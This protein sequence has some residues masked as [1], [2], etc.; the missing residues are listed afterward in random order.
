[1][2]IGS[3]RWSVDEGDVREVERGGKIKRCA[4][5]VE[6][7]QVRRCALACWKFGTPVSHCVLR[8]ISRSFLFFLSANLVRG[9]E[10]EEE[11]RRKKRWVRARPFSARSANLGRYLAAG[12][13]QMRR[14][15]THS[16]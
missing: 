9:R 3:G 1:M 10:A 13:L 2:R 16:E 14:E 11:E 6:L 12:C 8:R 4:A 15:S 5:A 7:P